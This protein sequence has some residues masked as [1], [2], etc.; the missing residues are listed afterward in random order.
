LWQPVRQPDPQITSIP[1]CSVLSAGRMEREGEWQ[2]LDE[3]EATYSGMLAGHLGVANT[4][5]HPPAPAKMK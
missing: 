4:R 5:P 1:L 3:G 2:I